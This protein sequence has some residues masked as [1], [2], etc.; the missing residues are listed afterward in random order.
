MAL[1]MTENQ[2][3]GIMLPGVGLGVPV[4]AGGV[5]LGVTGVHVGVGVE[6]A[7]EPGG[8]K[9]LISAPTGL[10]LESTKTVNNAA[11]NPIPVINLRLFLRM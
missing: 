5:G 7:D 4:P 10:V 9:G 6:S 8:N 2:I 11:N 3:L 1:D